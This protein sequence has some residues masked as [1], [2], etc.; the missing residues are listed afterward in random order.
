MRI[1]LSA[2]CV[3][4]LPTALSPKVDESSPR[5]RWSICAMALPEGLTERIVDTLKFSPHTSP[6]PQLSSTDIFIMAAKDMTN[7]L[8]HPHPEVQFSHVGDDT[9]TTLTEL[10]EIF[11]KNQKFKSPELSHSPIKADENKRPSTLTQPIFTYPLQHKFQ[12]RS[13]I[14]I[15]TG[16]AS[17]MPFLPRVITP[18]TGQAASPRVPARSQNLSPRNVSQNDL[19]RMETA[20]DPAIHKSTHNELNPKR[21]SQEVI[22]ELTNPTHIRLT[23]HL[24]DILV[25]VNMN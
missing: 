9:I 17:D 12:T 5:G 7:S 19:C 8:K 2:Y 13:Q 24:E 1:R 16:G 18:M 23:V 14:A 3:I 15:N 20:V 6:M 10:A 22:D 25:I 4:S 11:K 21:G